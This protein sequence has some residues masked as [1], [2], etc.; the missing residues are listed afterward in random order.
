MNEKLSEILMN[1]NK[2]RL[3]TEKIEKSFVRKSLMIR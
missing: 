3:K 1:N 2:S